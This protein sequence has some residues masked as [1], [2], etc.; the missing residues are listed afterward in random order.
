MTTFLE[1]SNSQASKIRVLVVDDSSLIRR[2]V[3]RIFERDP[4]IVLTG[5]ACKGRDALGKLGA[6][7]PDVVS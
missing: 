6:M 2:M 1:S 3:S 5:T 4:E 7:N